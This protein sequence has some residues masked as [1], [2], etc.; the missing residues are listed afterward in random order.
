MF[1]KGTKQKCVLNL[2]VVVIVGFVLTGC[3]ALVYG[4]PGVLISEISAC[5]PEFVELYNPTDQVVSLEGFYFSYY[6]ANRNSWENPY[7]VK[8]FPDGAVIQPH[9]F[10]LIT[11]GGNTSGYPAPDWNVYTRKMIRGEAGTV[12]ILDTKPG[13]GDV[14]D[15]VGWG[16][17]RLCLGTPALAPPD[18]WALGRKSGSNKEKPFQDKGD[19]SLDFSATPPSPS[20]SLIGA[21]LIQSGG[22]T[23]ENGT[24]FR[25]LTIYNASPTP[26][27]FRIQVESN[28]GLQAIP[29]P[30][31]VE[32]KPDERAQIEIFLKKYEFY[33]FDLETS[34]LNTDVCSI[35]EV[36]WAHFRCG[37]IREDYSSLVHY[38]GELAPFITF[39]TGITS[40]MLQT[41]PRPESVIPAV[42]DRFGGHPVV[43]YS[44]TRFDQRFLQS[45]ASSLGLELPNIQWISAYPWAKKAFPELPNYKLETVTE[46][47]GIE[48]QHHRALPDAR[49]TGIAFLEF[50]KRVG[51]ELVVHVCPTGCQHFAA[52]IALPIDLSLLICE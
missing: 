51:S 14:V 32:L 22:V 52:A 4:T 26:H 8:P 35:I 28:I 29:Q 33:V 50:L 31:T 17:T 16:N 11:V 34:G 10:F 23:I 42:L 27:T 20:G 24:R 41:A 49:M 36:G 12:A 21:L 46:K 38:E 30:Y 19:N 9:R 7:R 15:A 39:L 1:W 6:S 25:T 37:K 43:F 45:A 13:R 48:D 40:E 3:S 2:L 44:N 5:D 18:G 47:L